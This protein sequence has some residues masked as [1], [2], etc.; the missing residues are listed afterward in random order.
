MPKLLL[1]SPVCTRSAQETFQLGCTY[2]AQLEAGSCL[3]LVGELG[4]GKTTF[5]QGLAQGLG[6]RDPVGSPSYLIVQEHA[7]PMPLFHV[8][9]YRLKT[10]QE[11]AEIGFEEYLQAGGVVAV[12]WADNAPQALPA[13]TQW[14]YFTINPDGTRQIR[15]G[16]PAAPG[17]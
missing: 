8:D 1:E 12:E 13:S 17:T 3:A 15:L 16:R 7:G 10:A 9:C 14:I 11:L 6:V 4:A 5:V 2:G